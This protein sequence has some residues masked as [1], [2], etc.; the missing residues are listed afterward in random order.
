M[1]LK[2]ITATMNGTTYILELGADGK[3]YATIPA[4]QPADNDLIQYRSYPVTIHAE[5]VAG[6]ISVKDRD[7]SGDILQ[8]IVKKSVAINIKH[9]EPPDRFNA[10]DYNRIKYNICYIK[11]IADI[12]F[13]SVEFVGMGADKTWEEDPAPEDFQRIEQNLNYISVAAGLPEEDFPEH[14]GNSPFLNYE[15][16]NKIE[17]KCRQLFD[18]L[19]GTVMA[20]RRL[21]FALGKRGNL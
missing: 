12:I 11:Q 18:W 5:D 15:E 9:W 16:L 10:A 4:P 17:E 8:I 2:S 21:P 3:Y 19:Y 1:S 7:N 14:G 20:R 6:N 13:D